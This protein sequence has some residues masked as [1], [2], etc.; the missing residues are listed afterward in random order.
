MVLFISSLADGYLGCFQFRAIINKA[1]M[2][3]KVKSLCGHG[4]HFGDVGGKH[5]FL[6]LLVNVCLIF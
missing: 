2:K 1:A 5:R 4:F 6:S 3:I